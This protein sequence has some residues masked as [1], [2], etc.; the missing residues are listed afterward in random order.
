MIWFF[1]REGHDRRSCE[2]RL[3]FDGN[4]YELVVREGDRMRIERF[5]EL[6]ALLAREQELLQAWQSLGWR[7]LPDRRNLS[8]Q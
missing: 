7:G 2:T 6:S 3:A 1:T 5:H 8:V 4:G